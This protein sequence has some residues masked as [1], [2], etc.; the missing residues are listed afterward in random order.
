[1]NN[2]LFV[3]SIGLLPPIWDRM[4]RYEEEDV[5][6]LIPSRDVLMRFFGLK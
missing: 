5:S 3:F 4:N 2:F 6:N 1:M